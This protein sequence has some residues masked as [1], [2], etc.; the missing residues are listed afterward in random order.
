MVKQREL[1]VGYDLGLIDGALE[2]CV[3]LRIGIVGSR[4]CILYS[5]FHGAHFP[6]YS[7]HYRYSQGTS[8]RLCLRSWK[9]HV[10]TKSSQFTYL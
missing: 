9:G 6:E 8:A 4:T 7:G 1:G 3:K 5:R 10:S 2:I